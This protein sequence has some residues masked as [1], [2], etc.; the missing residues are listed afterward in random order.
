M[1]ANKSTQR[2]VQFFGIIGALTA[3]GHGIF[4]IRQ[5]NASTSDILARIG[6]YTLLPNYLITGICTIIISLGIIGW[7]SLYVHKSY[8]P[9]I[10]LVLIAV[11]FFVGGGVAPIFGLMITLIVSTQIRNPLAWWKALNSS[12]SLKLFAKIYNLLL[13]IGTISLLLGICVWLFLTPPGHLYKIDIIDYI[14]WTLLGFGTVLILLSIFAGF[15]Q[16]VENQ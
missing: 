6:A 3:I 13:T 16:D 7:L 15:S 9:I 12:N 11:L 8:G 5:G 10:F 2:F 4:E 1:N 14:C